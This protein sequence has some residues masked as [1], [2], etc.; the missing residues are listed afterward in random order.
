MEVH[1]DDACRSFE[2]AKE[3]GRV[4]GDR[5]SHHLQQPPRGVTWEICFTVTS[6]ANLLMAAIVTIPNIL[7]M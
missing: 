1:C 5:V 4:V 6:K 3:G 2:F 7:I